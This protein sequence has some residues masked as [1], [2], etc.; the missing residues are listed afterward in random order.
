MKTRAT[1]DRWWAA[2]RGAG[3]ARL[4]YEIG[5]AVLVA[6]IATVSALTSGTVPAALAVPLAV[7][8]LVLVPLRLVYP[9]GAFAASA[10]VGAATGG[11]NTV[12]MVVLGLAAGYRMT[13]LGRTAAAFA[14][15]LLGLGGTLLYERTFD[16]GSVVVLVAAYLIF[17][18]LPA[19]VARIVARRRT[20]VTAMHTRNVQ[21]YD[22]Q[23]AVARQARE[24]ERTRIAR[25]LHDS[26]GHQLTLISLY[27]GTLA[28][29]DD[30]Q[31]ESTVGLL[32]ATSAAA[33]GELRQILGILHEENGDAHGVAQPLSSL[34]D[35]I[36]RARTAGAEV[37][38]GRDGES[39]PLAPMVEH[40]A[41]R[42][43]Q[44][45][46]TNALR[47]AR[48]G[49]VRVTLRYEPDAVIAE[50]VN[51]P[52]AP[53]DGPTTGQGLIGLGERIRLAGGALYHGRTPAGGFRI[54]AMLPY[55][56]Q[57]T[58]VTRPAGDFT[59]QMYRSAQRSRIGLIA[60]GIG[61]AGVV[62]LCGG[63]LIL[64]ETVLT[65]DRDTYDAATVG[66]REDAVRDSLPD[67]EAATVGAV[68]GGPAPAGAT[69][70]DYQGSFIAQLSDENPGD[71]H[72][73][74]CFAGGVLVAKQV[75]Y[76][77]TA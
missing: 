28:T 33:M 8:T 31:R 4:T 66:Q 69:C 25:D 27:T 53:H 60:V 64:G 59:Q 61:I 10:L 50:V 71:L 40:A 7:S 20:L 3:P 30:E 49:A 6:V 63:V 65:V 54:A 24:R 75:F 41:Y 21:L 13:H 42:V 18:V 62:G 72:Y 48:G 36:S 9:A 22:Q 11:Q 58:P 45:G 70:L 35:L 68:G 16:L 29:A 17:A 1:R 32:R 19:V 52:G 12:V 37:T 46:V 23:A 5:L 14:V 43:I 15:G 34:D 26:L 73:R 56:G 76:E 55:E 47:H 39:R 38:L 77:P 51:D 67:P 2:A 74:F 57:A 44:E